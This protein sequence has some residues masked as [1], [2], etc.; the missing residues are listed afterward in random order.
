MPREQVMKVKASAKRHRDF[1][2]W[3][4]KRDELPVRQL[5]KLSPQEKAKVWLEDHMQARKD[6]LPGGRLAGCMYSLPGEA[7]GP[8]S[9]MYMGSRR[10]WAAV[11]W[12]NRRVARGEAVEQ[13]GPRLGDFVPE[14]A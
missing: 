3:R 7:L 1:E 8:H 9:A 4:R 12:H 11:V 10:W 5:W 14:L 6:R 2:D 13:F